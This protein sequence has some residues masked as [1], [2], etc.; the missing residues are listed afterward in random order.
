[1]RS[2]RRNL[3]LQPDIAPEEED[4][5]S[6]GDEDRLLQEQSDAESLPTGSV[7]RQEQE[8]TLSDDVNVN[9]S[10]DSDSGEADDND[11][12]NSTSHDS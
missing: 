6:G 2:S 5:S 1:M 3:G 9:D 10:T 7:I 8:S 11:D 12:Y 4:S